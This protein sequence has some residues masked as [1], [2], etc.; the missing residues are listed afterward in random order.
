MGIHPWFYNFRENCKYIN[1]YGYI[2]IPHIENNLTYIIAS[3]TRC[4]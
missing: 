1:I 2:Y 4:L 3:I